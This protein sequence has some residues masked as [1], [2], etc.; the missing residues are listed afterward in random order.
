MPSAVPSRPA[1]Q[2]QRSR[3]TERRI[4]KAALQTLGELGE[5]GI[6]MAAV[7]DRAG[8]SVG[9]IYRR[10]GSREELLIAMATEFA[11]SFLRQVQ[12]R[13]ASACPSGLATPEAIVEHATTSVART[14]QRNSRAFSRLVLMGLT[15]PRIFEEGQ[16][17]S[18]AGGE[19]YA[20]F[21]LHARS[22]IRRPDPA[23]AVDY[24]YRL[25]YAMCTHRIT[26]GTRLE[27]RRSFSWDR[28]IA[29]LVEVNIGYLL[30][31]PARS[32]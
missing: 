13:L 18:I 24:T 23:M 32:M 20:R 27:S 31:P 21:V 17:A 25:I 4:L 26:Q 14:F 12:T 3:L 6:T 11:Q 19:E 5:S 7:S 16:R 30:T 8:V 2:Q 10:F 28:I 1:A 9:S 29:E 15:E 22:A